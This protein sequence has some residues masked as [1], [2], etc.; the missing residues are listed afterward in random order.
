MREIKDH[1]SFRLSNINNTVA[2]YATQ[3]EENFE[4][5]A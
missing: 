1:P 4:L 2:R 5:V 3:A